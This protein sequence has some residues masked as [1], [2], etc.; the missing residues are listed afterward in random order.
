MSEDETRQAF[1][2]WIVEEQ[3]M[4]RTKLTPEQIRER[5]PTTGGYVE[6][7]VQSAWLG[8]LAGSRWG[9]ST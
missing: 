6:P 9:I 1:E 2:A 8:W 3:G 7:L 4:G 5:W